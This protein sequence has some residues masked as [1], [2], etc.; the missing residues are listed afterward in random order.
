MKHQETSRQIRKEINQSFQQLKETYPLLKWQDSIGLSIFLLSIIAII[1]VSIGWYKT[2]IPTWLMIVINAFFMGVLHEI[3]H[4]LIHWLYFKKYKP[5]HHF[6]LFTVWILRPLTVNPWI[7][8]KM[9]YH[10]HKFSGTLHDVEE[11]SVTNG[12]R[13]SVKRLLM[14]PDVVLGGLF[15][16]YQMH[17]D[18]DREVKNGNLKEE[19]SLTLKRIT[20]LSIIPVTIFAHVVLYFFFADM[21]MNWMNGQ[22]GTHLGFPYSIENILRSLD[23]ITYTILL[24]NLLRQFCLHFITSNM[25]YFGDLEDGNVIEQT[26]VLNVWWTFPMQLFCFFFGWTHSIHHFVVNETFYVRHLGRKQAQDVLRKYGVRFND[27]GTFRRA[28]RFREYSPK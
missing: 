22:F 24:P 17:S 1:A 2:L 23:I 20:F 11:R 19:T 10:H 14:T 25:H 5:I 4:D 3:E 16:L 21:L 7:R 18:M 26:Q 28:N 15:R 12:E 9:H 13:W 8:R 6:M 27:L